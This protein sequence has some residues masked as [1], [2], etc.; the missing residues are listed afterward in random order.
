MST[1]REMRRAVN[2]TQTAAADALGVT[3]AS[4]GAWERGEARP[5][6]DKLQPMARLYGVSLEPLVAAIIGEGDDTHDRRIP[7][8]EPGDQGGPRPAAN[9]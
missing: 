5:T 2:L 4:L 3:Q 6:L 7:P 1:L 8:D 9:M